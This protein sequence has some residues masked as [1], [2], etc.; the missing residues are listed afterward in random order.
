MASHRI[1]FDSVSA[2]ERSRLL[3]DNDRLRQ[4]LR[5][6]HRRAEIAGSSPGIRRVCELIGQLAA[7]THSVCLVGE[8]GVGKSRVARALHG[9][10]VRAAS[11]LVT[12]HCPSLLE[13]DV[14]AQ[15]FGVDGLR[16]SPARPGGCVGRAQGGTLFFD[17]LAALGLRAQNRLIRL[18]RE[19]VWERPDGVRLPVDVRVVVATTRAV[20]QLV[21]SG[22]CRPDLGDHLSAMTITVPPLRER[23]SDLPVLTDLFVEQ[24]SRDHVRAARRVSARAM[25][26]LMNYDWPGNVAELRH[27]IERAVVLTTGPVI[28]HHHLPREIQSSG[29]GAPAAL[30]LNEA[31]DACERELLQDALRQAGGVRSVAARL[32]MTSERVLSYRLRKHQIDTR[33]FKAS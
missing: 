3:A 25:D 20:G 4:Q 7:S 13:N 11:S 10:S 8:P 2:A 29:D 24:F 28:H 33:R 6:R 18:V 21:G 22:H 5:D 31:V 16:H 32:L 27:T 14:D 26:M 15:L 30:G 23:K 17:E 9:S 19:H 12:V 1:P